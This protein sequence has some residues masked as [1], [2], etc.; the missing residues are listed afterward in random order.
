MTVHR[1]RKKTSSAPHLLFEV[2]SLFLIDQHQVEVITHRELLVDVPHGWSQLIASQEKPDGNGLPCKVHRTISTGRM[3]SSKL[4]GHQRNTSLGHKHCDHLHR[5]SK[6]SKKIS[7]PF[8]N[9]WPDPALADSY[10]TS[11]SK[12]MGLTVTFIKTAL[13]EE[14]SKVP[15]S[16]AEENVAQ[17]TGTE[18]EHHL[19]APSCSNASWWPMPA[20]NLHLFHCFSTRI[21]SLQLIM[22]QFLLIRSEKEGDRV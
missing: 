20:G 21:K 12:S 6:M 11:T 10:S 4:G 9:P 18:L 7:T 17:E 15:F 14:M 8:R 19:S 22:P 2:A 13:Q 3:H 16:L 1:S 5:W